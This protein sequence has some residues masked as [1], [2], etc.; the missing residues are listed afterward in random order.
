M[1]SRIKFGIALG[2]LLAAFADAQAIDEYQVK[3]AFV[4]NFAKFVEWPPHTFKTGSDPISICVLG[5]NPFG[6]SLEEAVSDKSI[7]GRA[8]VVR[9]IP[10]IARADGCQILFVA[11]K[12]KKSTPDVA[13]A[14]V[15]TVGES[16]GF[17]AGGGVIGFK[18]DGGKVRLEINIGAADQ[19]KLRIS[20][21]L[22]SIAQIVKTEAR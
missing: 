7:E 16:D 8:F 12:Q 2:A 21:K 10:E 13:L 6:R 3:A 4:Y 1:N 19:H 18:L 14:G 15:L 11:A 17:A 22:L 20:S 5:P 9:Q